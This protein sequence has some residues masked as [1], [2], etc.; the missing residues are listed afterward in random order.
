MS[1]PAAYW[2]AVAIG[3]LVCVTL[4]TA[5]RRWPGP[6]VVWAGRAISLVLALDAVVY[7]VVPLVQRSWSVHASLPLAL[8]NLALL[9]AAVACWWPSWSLAVELTYFWGLAGALQA[10]VT[11]DLAAGFPQLEF[12]EF[13]VGHLGV[14]IAA[15]YLVVGL[16]LQPRPG[17]VRRVF[18]V[19]AAYTAFVGWFDWLTGS[20]Y[21][22][23]A[24]IP[25]TDSL[26]SVLGPWPW[27]ILS[28][29][30][31]ALVL[32]WLL[33][34]PFRQRRPGSGLVSGR[35]RTPPRRRGRAQDTDTDGRNA[36][37]D[38]A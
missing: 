4:C 14:V 21:M 12:F 30:G 10:V 1:T 34:L 26:L 25:A 22:F 19:T 11:P 7:V 16:R 2:V 20:N 5:C 28:A 35:G 24:A 36:P 18:A 15:L 17:S 27:Y 6:W 33:D 23:L 8:C 29:A 38:A 9:V 31:V 37:D 3:A 13:V 32:F